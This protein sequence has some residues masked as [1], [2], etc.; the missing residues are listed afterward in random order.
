V[1]AFQGVHAA[2]PDVRAA[3]TRIAEDEAEHAELSWD[4]D[5]WYGT[6]LTV[7]ERGLVADAKAEAL[8]ALAADCD[9]EPA[10]EV[11]RLGGMPTAA[12]ARRL[13]DLLPWAVTA[14]GRA[15]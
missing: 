4:L 6:R 10:A 8:A 14:L 2:D 9:A 7:A 15:A 12:E 1:A 13:L 11:R 5:A 3:F